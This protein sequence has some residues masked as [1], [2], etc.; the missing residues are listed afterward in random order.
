MP[1]VKA[2]GQDKSAAFGLSLW[3][4]VLGDIDSPCT[5]LI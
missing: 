1:N 3:S 2:Q 5:Q 4:A